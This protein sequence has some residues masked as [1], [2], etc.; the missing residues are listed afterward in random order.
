MSRLE[1]LVAIFA[2]AGCLAVLPTAALAQGPIEQGTKQVGGLEVTLLSAPPLSPA[3]MQQMMPGMGGMGGMQG[4]GSMMR[5]MPGMGGMGGGPAQP[6]HWIGVIIR[7]LKDGRVVPDLKIT[8]SAQKDGLTRNAAL[9]PMPGSYGANISLLEKG[10]YLVT[11][12][13][14]RQGQPLQVAFEFDYR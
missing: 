8:L 14:G 13:I 11:I 6:T 9:M 3:E 2:I 7:D 10:R 1:A 5:G 12:T 4:M